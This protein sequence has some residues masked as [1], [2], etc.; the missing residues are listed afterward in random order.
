MFYTA[1]DANLKTDQHRIQTDGDRDMHLK[2][3]HSPLLFT[4]TECKVIM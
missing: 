4:L 3:L 1:Y 2:I